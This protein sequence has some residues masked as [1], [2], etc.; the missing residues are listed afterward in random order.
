MKKQPILLIILSVM[1]LFSGCTSSRTALSLPQPGTVVHKSPN[2]ESGIRVVT[3]EVA[4]AASFPTID[5]KD[6]VGNLP[7][8]DG[9][10]ES[11]FEK[12]MCMA[13]ITMTETVD[14][15]WYTSSGELRMP[16]TLARC[17]VNA[18]YNARPECTLK[19][20]DV[21]IVGLKASMYV[22]YQAVG[23]LKKGG[24]YMVSLEDLFNPGFSGWRHF[25]G[26]AQYMAIEDQWCHLEVTGKFGD[27]PKVDTVNM[28][29]IY[30]L[31]SIPGCENYLEWGTKDVAAFFARTQ[32][33][34][35]ERL[36]YR[37]EYY[38]GKPVAY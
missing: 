5:P 29:L 24:R 22:P 9:Y 19:A 13:D 11:A 16:T 17:R 20:G 15:L 26:H 31:A 14:C 4:K 33:A 12:I 23:P 7:Y 8:R 30:G 25:A 35:E 38:G 37:F 2:S 28:G 18:V 3:P 1:L 10:W 6:Y 34:E 36:G 32:A 27:N 21:V